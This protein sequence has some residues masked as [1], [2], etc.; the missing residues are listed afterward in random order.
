MRIL[1]KSK[2]MNDSCRG[3]HGQKNDLLLKRDALGMKSYAG[4]EVRCNF[5]MV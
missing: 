5:C 2:C 4:K 3:M 1:N